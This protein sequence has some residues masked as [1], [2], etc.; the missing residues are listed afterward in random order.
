[1]IEAE[2]GLPCGCGG[3]GHLESYASGGAADRAARELYGEGSSGEELV[4]KAREGDSRAVDALSAIGRSL[5]AGI[6]SFVNVFEP[7]VLVI[8][9]GFGSAAGELLLGPAREVLAQDG[10]EP[11]RDT[12]KIVQ[13][14]LGYQAG[15]IGAGMI[16]FEAL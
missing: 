1:V 4:S 6:A 8:G 13:A 12:V 5:G 10:L 3:R 11:A 14:E 9:G 15:V 16:A 7:E 2:N